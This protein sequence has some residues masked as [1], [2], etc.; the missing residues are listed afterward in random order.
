MAK[1]LSN[2]EFVLALFILGT[3][4]FLFMEWVWPHLLAAT[5]LMYSAGALVVFFGTVLFAISGS[6]APGYH[7]FSA[8]FKTQS[9]GGDILDTSLPV[10]AV[11][12]GRVG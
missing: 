9:D 4:W 3:S 2:L 1:T 11:R 8:H 10:K 6:P 12:S 5:I 7:P